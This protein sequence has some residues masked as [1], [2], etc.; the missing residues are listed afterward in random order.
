MSPA[1]DILISVERQLDIDSEG[2]LIASVLSKKAA[3]GSTHVVIDIP[4][5]PTAKIRSMDTANQLADIMVTVGRNIGMN[6][7]A[8]IT[9]GEQ[10]VGRGIGPALEARDVLSVL[11]GEPAAP[12]DLRE[13]SL[14]L[15][16]EL[17]ELSGKVPG[18]NGYKEASAILDKGLAWKKFKAIC[19]SQGGLRELPAAEHRFEVTADR[20]GLITEIDNRKLALVAKLAG[21][22]IAPA[23]GIDLHVKKGT[24]VYKGQPL[25]TLHAEAPGELDY[26]LDYIT[27]QKYI[28]HIES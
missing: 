17:L 23:A 11:Q 24:A 16:G 26:A 27:R 19:E 8:I 18:N 2:Q 9:D 7:R 6:I 28:L 12:A 25:F 15:A 13:R 10:P 14:M 1:D 22:P 3:A 21:A 4:V 20:E 5:G